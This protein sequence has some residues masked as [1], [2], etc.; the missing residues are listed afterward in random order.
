MKA[1][2]TSLPGV[3]VIEGDEHTDDRGSVAELYR[4]DRFAQLGIPDVFV[5][6]NLTR[7]GRGA[8]RGLH[9]RIASQVKLVMVTEGEIYD[10]AVDVRRGSPT[11]GQWFGTQL[12]AENRRR[13][14]IPPGFAHGYQAISERADVVY[15]L[16]ATFDRADDRAI[17]WDDPAL[18]IGWPLAASL[19][20][21]RDAAAPLL[22]DAALPAFETLRR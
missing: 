8:V 3:I 20:S 14:Y 12:T 16:T 13:V 7:S 5:Q 11:F 6:D 19:L 22:A 18:A 1:S 10:V 4:V 9:Y 2:T 21:A 17:R 15:K